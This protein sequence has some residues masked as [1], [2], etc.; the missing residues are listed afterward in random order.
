MPSEREGQIRAFLA[1]AGWERAARRRLAGDASSRRYDRLEGGAILMQADAA[2]TARFLR[3]A[4]HLAGLG[5][6][7]PRIFA[8]DP[9]TGLTLIEDFGDGLFANLLPNRPELEPELYLA[10]TDVLLALRGAPAPDLPDYGAAAMVAAISPAF[11]WY[12]GGRSAGSVPARLTVAFDAL[13]R[14]QPSL[15]LR[16]YHAEN[17]FWLPDRAGPAR[18]GLID[19][20]DAV[21]THPA[22]DLASLAADVRRDVAPGT[23]SAMLDRFATVA[24]LGRAG[25]EQA[26]ATL[27]VQRNLR[28]LGVFARLALRGGKP[29]YLALLPRVWARLEEG[30][31]HPG[32]AALRAA[33]VEALPAPTGAHIASLERRCRTPQPHS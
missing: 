9:E 3:L 32:L 2:E 29:R 30:L 13:P 25:L 4:V 18:V 10:A 7:P 5:L 19:F 28:I 1:G 15:A 14:W 16:D 11:D 33:V 17:L 21:L 22:Y 6:T 26:V 24:G 31:A 12:A 27:S 8:A 23:V 20:Q